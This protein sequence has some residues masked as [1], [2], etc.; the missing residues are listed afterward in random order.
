[1]YEQWSRISSFPFDGVKR[2]RLVSNC[3]GK[4]PVKANLH[5]KGRTTIYE[6]FQGAPWS[7]VQIKPIL[8]QA[9]SSRLKTRCFPGKNIYLCDTYRILSGFSTSESDL[10]ALIFRLMSYYY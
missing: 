1:M 2:C 4:G 8:N 9:L 3:R 7:M 10:L 6:A 5:D